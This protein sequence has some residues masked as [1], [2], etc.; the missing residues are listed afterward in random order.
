MKTLHLK[1]I[2]LFGLSLLQLRAQEALLSFGASESFHQTSCSVGCLCFQ[3]TQYYNYH[4]NEGVQQSYSSIN[5]VPLELLSF[6]GHCQN[7]RIHLQWVT[8]SE[9]DIMCFL[10]EKSQDG[11]LFE[12]VN[13]LPAHG[14]SNQKQYYGYQDNASADIQYYKLSQV[15]HNGIRKDLKT[16]ALQCH[17]NTDIRAEMNVFP[18]P[19]NQF[20]QIESSE[21]IQ[22]AYLYD[23]T[24]KLIYH[25]SFALPNP[26]IQTS[27][28]AK[29]FYFFKIETVTDNVVFKLSKN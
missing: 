16:I 7:D 1:L 19:F 11:Y 15:E 12:S 24:G 10:L 22:A 21:I 17:E 29:G 4:I 8:A 6:D 5:L 13:T 9:S 23:C 25:E 27:F 28:L 18:N 3:N 26:Q 14:A 2:F 20:I